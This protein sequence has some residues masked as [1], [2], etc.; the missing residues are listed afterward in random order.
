MAA[1]GVPALVVCSCRH[2]PPGDWL[3]CG[4]PRGGWCCR[5]GHLWQLHPG[6]SALL[7]GW[8]VPSSFLAGETEAGATLPLQV[9]PWVTGGR[10]GE[11]DLKKTPTFPPGQAAE[12]AVL[13]LCSLPSVLGGAAGGTCCF[14]WPAAI[15]GGRG[16][17]QGPEPPSRFPL[18]PCCGWCPGGVRRSLQPSSSPPTV[19][20]PIFSFPPRFAPQRCEPWRWH[21]AWRG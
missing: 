16:A 12:V 14:C 4:C 20:S 13:G 19:I 9:S 11:L 15:L 18:Y 7:G 3:G 1:R 6:S 5:A 8:L 10:Q 21:R 2:S 17:G